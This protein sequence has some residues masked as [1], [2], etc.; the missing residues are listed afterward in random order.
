[1]DGQV[2]NRRVEGVPHMEPEEWSSLKELLSK[3]PELLEQ[4]DDLN[5]MTFM[6][7]LHFAWSYYK[8]RMYWK[9]V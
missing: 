1:M 4:D 9:E 3:A 5:L 7:A 8:N 6:T 2:G